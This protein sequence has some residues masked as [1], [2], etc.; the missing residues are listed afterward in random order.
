MSRSRRGDRSGR[1]KPVSEREAGEDPAATDDVAELLDGVSSDEG[2]VDTPVEAVESGPMNAGS[3]HEVTVEH[4]PESPSHDMDESVKADLR[5]LAPKKAATKGGR[6][7]PKY[8]IKTTAHAQV[9][10][11]GISTGDT[12][13]IAPVEKWRVEQGGRLMVEGRLCMVARGAIVT[14]LTHDL[15]KMREAGIELV[16]IGQSPG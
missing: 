16:L 6:K 12:S 3:A 14:R 7:L 5:K 4:K 15:K 9:M 13:K 8:Q 2:A 1:S 11:R 10:Q